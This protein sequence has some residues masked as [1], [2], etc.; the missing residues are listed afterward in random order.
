MLPLPHYGIKENQVPIHMDVPRLSNPLDHSDM[1]Q[2]LITV[3][4]RQQMQCTMQCSQC[5]AL[6]CEKTK[7]SIGTLYNKV[8][9]R[10][11]S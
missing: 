9:Y 2:K 5:Y 10:S 6:F 3:S 11:S 1:E 7:Q 8:K 4:T